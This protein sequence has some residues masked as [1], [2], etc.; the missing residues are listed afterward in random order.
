[1]NQKVR[2]NVEQKGVEKGGSNMSRKN[3]RQINYKTS[4]RGQYIFIRDKKLA[5]A[6][7]YL[8]DIPPFL[9]QNDYLF[10]STIEFWNC[11]E[12]LQSY[13]N[14]QEWDDDYE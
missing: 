4:R 6:L 1:M 14:P 12:Y 7:C 3:K 5:Y 9:S 11:V 13:N 10:K 8:L 2:R